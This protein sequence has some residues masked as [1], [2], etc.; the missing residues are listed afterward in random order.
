MK[1]L[2]LAATSL[3]LTIL[4][5]GAAHADGEALYASKACVA[6]HGPEGKQPSVM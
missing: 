4:S 6:C 2:K 5:L 1:P 3:I